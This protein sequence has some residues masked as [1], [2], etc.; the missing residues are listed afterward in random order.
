M[1]NLNNL[2]KCKDDSHG[3]L[4]KN[5]VMEPLPAGLDRGF[6]SVVSMAVQLSPL[7]GQFPSRCQRYEQAERLLWETRSAD[8]FASSKH[9]IVEEKGPL[10][11]PTRENLASRNQSWLT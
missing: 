6:L 5:S 4:S 7:R 11:L 1:S 10:I 9:A 3:G 8:Q 2:Y